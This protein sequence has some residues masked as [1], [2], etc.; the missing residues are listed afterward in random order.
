MTKHPMA[1]IPTP[2]RRRGMVVGV[3]VGLAV[4]AS[5]GGGGSSG[6]KA[7]DTK[8]TTTSSVAPSSAG[9][10]GSGGSG[11]SNYSR[12]LPAKVR[13]VNL[14]RRSGAG[15]T[16]DVW[17]GSAQSGKKIT[18]IA[19]GKISDPITPL[20][21]TFSAATKVSGR[22]VYSYMFTVYTEGGTTEKERVISQGEQA[23]P[24]DELIMLVGPGSATPQ[25]F[26]P[27]AGA[28]QVL[29]T[30]TDNTTNGGGTLFAKTKTP[31]GR[32][33]LYVNA[34]GVPIGE[35]SAGSTSTSSI[36]SGGTGL[37]FDV[38]ETGQGC[39]P[40]VGPQA[41]APGDTH[42][43]ALI[44]PQSLGGFAYVVSP[45]AQQVSLYG[46]TDGGCK[47]SPIGGPFA[48][49]ANSGDHTGLLLYGPP[50]DLKSLVISL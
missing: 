45:G 24:G 30:K 33:L 10:G 39:L 6:L 4:L 47:Q 25:S 43:R 17:A 32:G 26:A 11:A 1:M 28:D 37:T 42:S 19:Y 7:S 44:S 14:Y 22:D 49:T 5:C 2:A 27:A 35:A 29:F 46:A 3:A 20:A 31:A 16:I 15:H 8:G 13:V 34:L 40:E 38:G 48:V 21:S 12:K 50:D 23:F 36:G 18:S 9:T 41:P